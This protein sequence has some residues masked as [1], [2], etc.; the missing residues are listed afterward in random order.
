MSDL[1]SASEVAPDRRLEF[2]LRVAP[3]LLLVLSLAFTLALGPFDRA[4][5][6][7]LLGLTGA[8]ALFR[9]WWPHRFV[10]PWVRAAGFVVHLGLTL[11][12]VSLSPLYGVYA[13]VGYL[14]AVAVFKGPTLSL[15]LIAAASMNALAQSGGP[16]GVLA[17][18][19]LFLFLIAANGGL[20]V[21]MVHVDRNRQRTVT[22]LQ[23]AL[24][25]LDRA[26]EANAQLQGQLLAQAR[27]SGVLEE[28][29]RL[30]RE[31][32]DTV[33]QGL[34][35]AL[36]QI[37]AAAEAATLEAARP[38]LSRA[39]RT[40]RES[41]AEARRAVMALAS[42]RLD[43]H[44]LREALRALVDTWSGD[45]G[46]L[47]DFAVAGLP[48]DT[49]HDADLFRVAQEALANVAKH[50][51]A[52]SANVLLTYSTGGVRLTVQDNGVGLDPECRAP[53]QGLPGMKAR[54]SA[55]GGS[56]DL[57][58]TEGGGCTVSAVVPR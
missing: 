13:F 45:A 23:E 11:A 47:A 2:G 3:L 44:T 24:A 34:I 29:Q 39:D 55:V 4:H 18:P 37:E 33:A 6:A 20:A 16:S 22:H 10:S 38:H 51:R 27:A 57:E 28:R 8:V 1:Q 31:I 40:A 26:H 36:R 5:L 14:D 54:M 15:G 48:A 17:Q 7:L 25:E 9:L 49:P 46:I 53:G 41:L 12:L 52:T 56:L 19:P 58:S 35:A 21:A 30:S 32:H 43:E 42:P 50:A